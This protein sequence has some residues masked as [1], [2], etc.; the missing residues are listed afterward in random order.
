[1][2]FYTA[3]PD[4]FVTLDLN[5]DVVIDAGNTYAL[6][7]FSNSDAFDEYDVPG[8]QGTVTVNTGEPISL[9]DTDSTDAADDPTQNSLDGTYLGDAQFTTAGFTVAGG[10]NVQLNPINGSL[11]QADDGTF[12]IVTD[13]PIREDGAASPR[14]GLTVTIP[15][16]FPLPDTV[17]NIELGALSGNPLTAAVAATV[18]TTLDTVVVG[19]DADGTGSIVVDDFLPCFTK[20]TVIETTRGAV[21]VEDLKIGDLVLTIDHGP[22]PV[23]WL[24]SR[25]LS[26]RGLD[27]LPNLRPIR[28]AA[29]A[30]GQGRPERD[31]LVSPQHRILVRSKIA[32]NMFGAAEVLVAAKQLLQLDGVDYARDVQEVDYFHIMFDA[33]E[34]IMSN[35]AE[36]E[37]FYTGDEALKS[38]NSA[39]RREI[40]ALF[41]DLRDRDPGMRPIGAKRLLSGREGRRL[42]QRHIGKGREL[43]ELDG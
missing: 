35:G 5:G 3:L 2:P 17:L 20:G 33:H 23:R 18:Q 15:G 19:V 7:Q 24:G 21:R 27:I 29:G 36:T 8:D 10:I 26:A 31:L 6:N 28:I 4:G 16:V 14:L 41:P 37:S 30:L 43:L 11:F 9:L 1:M 32:I 42:V 40:F 25:H 13:D 39:A 34:V 22:R 12:Y 38:L